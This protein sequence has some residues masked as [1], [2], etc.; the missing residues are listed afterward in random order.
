[1]SSVVK[2]GRRRRIST[3]TLVTILGL[4]GFALG[5]I[6]LM[7]LPQLLILPLL[8]LTIIT[9]VVAGL[10]A[11]GVRWMPALGALYCVGTMI[12][13]FLTNPYLP[14]HL[15]H[16]S[17]GGAFIAALFSYVCGL[18]VICAG[19]GATMQNYRGPERRAPRWLA[20]PLTG[21]AGFMLGALLVSLLVVA[22]P[23]PTS[24]ASTVN[25][26]PAVH[27][28]LS[29][30]VQSSV[31]IPKGSK[32]VLVDD[33]QYTHVLSNGSWV[34]NTQHPGAEAGAPAVSNVTVNSGNI[35]VGPFNSAGTFHIF[36]TIHQ[37]MNL[38]VIVQ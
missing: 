17:E 32:L 31:T 2:E 36:C 13:G 25:G 38:T 12:S 4:L 20:A 5:F 6:A 33:G 7:V 24:G 21:A 14:Y 16:P 11:T 10:V 3:L 35:E 30:F 19:I 28:G 15:T 1:M 8:I 27:M 23:T 26:M 34:N 9:L 37:G 22:T 18:I 29:S